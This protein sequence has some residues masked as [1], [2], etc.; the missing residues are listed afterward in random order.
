[1]KKV[2]FAFLAAMLLFN[3]TGKSENFTVTEV[4]GVNLYSNTDAPNNPEAKLELKKLFTISSESGSDSTAELRLPYLITEDG[5]QNIFVLDVMASNVK[6]YDSEGKFLKVI[7]REGQGPG[8]FYDPSIMYIYSD[9]LNVYSNGSTVISKFDL[10]GNFFYGKKVDRIQPQWFK[11]S[12]SGKSLAGFV[13]IPNL[14]KD[15][16]IADIDYCMIDL[17]TLTVKSCIQKNPMNQEEFMAGKIDWLIFRAPLATDDNYAY[18]SDNTD[19]QYR[20]LVYDHD[21]NKKSEI[22]KSYQKIRIEKNEKE[23]YIE[24]MKK[25]MRKGDEPKVDEFKKAIYEMYTDKYGRLLVIPSIDRHKGKDGV[26]VD[27]F[28]DGKFLNRVKYDLM[29]KSTIGLLWQVRSSVIFS[30]SRLYYLDR[31]K[32]VIDVYDY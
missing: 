27:I 28:K 15:R 26:Y 24:D 6:K 32:N 23:K 12:R 13:F 29:N 21:G 2:I 22:R 9:T 25:V 14:G 3:C 16:E 4:N 18:L 19:Y 31:D 17:K 5:Y 7:G 10:D 8:E 30:G 20:I 1:M 11:Y